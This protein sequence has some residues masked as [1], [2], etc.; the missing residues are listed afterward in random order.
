MPPEGRWRI[1]SAP[2]TLRVTRSTSVATVKSFVAVGVCHACCTGSIAK[3]APVM[4]NTTA[5]VP[6]LKPSQ[7]CMAFQLIRAPSRKLQGHGLDVL[8]A[9]LRLADGCFG[10]GYADLRGAVSHVFCRGIDA[11]LIA[12]VDQCIRQIGGHFE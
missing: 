5:R 7:R 3:T 8:F 10:Q 12:C 9:C 4:P 2:G 6:T 11:D 1:S